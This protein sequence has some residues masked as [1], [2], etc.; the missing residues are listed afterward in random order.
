MIDREL[1]N[2][3]F[4][5]SERAYA[6]YSKI[7]TGAALECKSGRVYSGCCVESASMGCCV[8]AE[9]AAIAAALAAGDTRFSRIAVAAETPDYCMP[10]GDARQL[11]SEFARDYDIEVLCARA[12]GGY[13]SYRISELL[14][15]PWEG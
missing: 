10:G 2:I 4:T 9:A 6:P 14:P 3:A 11:I 8:S 7:R 5:A 1:I 13:V 15:R 12:G